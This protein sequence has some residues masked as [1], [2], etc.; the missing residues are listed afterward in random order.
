MLY[1][2]YLDFLSIATWS[3]PKYA[4]LGWMVLMLVG[5]TYGR[6]GLRILLAILMALEV[7]RMTPYWAC[8]GYA[9]VDMRVPGTGRACSSDAY[10]NYL[11]KNFHIDNIWVLVAYAV[12]VLFLIWPFIDRIRDEVRAE[13][14]Q[15]ERDAYV[16][17]MSK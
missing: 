9:G 11:V 3:W 13:K 14:A 7:L 12:V 6:H 5:G 17:E 4:V 1:Q 15:K 8:H 2:T 16:R 10:Q